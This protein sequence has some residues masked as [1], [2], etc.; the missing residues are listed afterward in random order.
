[1][2]K[3]FQGQI[4]RVFLSHSSQ[5]K[6]VVRELYQKLSKDGFDVWFDEESLLPGQDWD[7]EIVHAVRHANI[8]IICLSPTSVTKSGYFQKEI[9]LALDAAAEKPD[10]AIFN[11]PA[12]LEECNVPESLSRYQ[13]VDLYKP[14]GYAR[15]IKALRFAE[16]KE[17]E[18]TNLAIDTNTKV[19]TGILN[20]VFASDQTLQVS[21]RKPQQVTVVLRSTGDLETD[22]KRIKQ[23]YATLRSYEGQD[24]FSFQVFENN[25]GHL[26]D[27]PDVTTRVCTELLDRLKKL[28][29]EQSWR[30]EEIEFE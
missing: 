30:A 2:G 7:R 8:V 22:R 29:G 12:R 5:D 1:M 15:L 24:R 26:I 23:I 27:F 6:A 20:P 10:G 9:R 3:V 28:M 13:W 16:A 21:S 11:I 17:E 4:M 14:E 18:S 25:K 19:E